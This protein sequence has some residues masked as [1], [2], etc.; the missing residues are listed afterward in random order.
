MNTN[1]A[2]IPEGYA[3][4]KNVVLNTDNEVVEVLDSIAIYEHDCE[5]DG[6]KRILTLNLVGTTPAHLKGWELVQKRG[7]MTVGISIGNGYFNKERLEVI[8]MGMANYFAEVLIIIPDLPT[9]HSYLALGYDEHHAMERVKKHRQD[10]SRCCRQ[11]S[12]QAESVF[13]KKNVNILTWSDHLFPKD[14]YRSAYDRAVA[15]YNSDDGFKESILRNTERYILARLEGQDVQQLGGMRKI[16]EK[17]ALYLVE[18]MAFHE[19][20][21]SIFGKDV[22]ASYYKGLELIPDYISGF[23]GNPQNCRA[24]FTVYNIAK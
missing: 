3:I 22:I 4:P 8:L 13:A 5:K 12:E 15:I 18:E 11:I 7:L 19:M 16:V 6:H 20:F 23:Y 10:I 24:G 14:Y 9:L 2:N 21:H 17:A 1:T